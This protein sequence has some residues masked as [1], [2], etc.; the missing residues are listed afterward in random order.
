MDHKVRTVLSQATLATGNRTLW[1]LQYRQ[2]HL[3]PLTNRSLADDDIMMNSR[4][5]GYPLSVKGLAFLP[6]LLGF[7]MFGALTYLYGRFPPKTDAT[8]GGRLRPSFRSSWRQ[9]SRAGARAPAPARL[10]VCWD[11]Q[12]GAATRAA[13]DQPATVKVAPPL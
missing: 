8:A 9:G 2:G 13:T 11:P 7:A 12:C 3:N 1:T 6:S 5:L 4:Y 10:V